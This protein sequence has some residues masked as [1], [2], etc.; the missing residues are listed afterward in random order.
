MQNQS[1]SLKGCFEEEYCPLKLQS[2]YPNMPYNL[3][4]GVSVQSRQ[5]FYKFTITQTQI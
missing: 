3:V 1:K 5:Q 4:S 2:F